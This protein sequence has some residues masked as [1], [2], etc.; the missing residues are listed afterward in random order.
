MQ[1]LCLSGGGFLG[2]YTASVLAELE[3]YSG[4]P[5]A[6]HFDLLAGTSIGGIIA[7]GLAARKP[8]ADIRDAMIQHGPKIFRSKPPPKS[9][10]AKKF[11]LARNAVNAKYATSPLRKIVETLVDPSVTIGDLSHRV[12]VPAINLTKGR[13]QV[14][15]TPH[16]PTF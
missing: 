12:I 11:H 7:L 3:A 14:F 13:P 4:R 5:I 1:I 16:H 6:D 9:E 8:A 2:L 10:M 15:K